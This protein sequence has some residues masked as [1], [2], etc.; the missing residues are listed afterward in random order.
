MRISGLTI[1][2]GNAGGGDGG[3]IDNF[4][5][6][7]VSDSVFSGNTAGHHG[8]GLENESG[9]TATVRDSTF[10]G[11]SVTGVFDPTV[12][13]PLGEGGG[14]HNRGTL[15]VRDSTLTG[16]TSASDGGG[17]FNA[18]VGTLEVS[19]STF[20]GNSTGDAGGGIM[21]AH[22]APNNGMATVRDCTFI[23]NIGGTRRVSGVD[24]TQA[25]AAASKATGR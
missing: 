21:N 18:A 5:T 15:T 23:G 4:G 24:P 9:G 1:A 22:D 20:T 2:G 13:L 7:S 19:G 12:P 25:S 8:G 6:L 11:N 14:I 17:I 3:G 16:N 10:T